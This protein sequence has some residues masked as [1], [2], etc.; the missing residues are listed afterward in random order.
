MIIDLR[1]WQAESWPAAPA[2]FLLPCCG[3]AARLDQPVNA[4][5]RPPEFAA[6]WAGRAS[7][8]AICEIR[9][10][11]WS[12]SAEEVKLVGDI[13]QLAGVDLRV[14]L[15]DPGVEAGL[16]EVRVGGQRAM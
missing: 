1:A 15:R 3:S 9:G 10:G 2:G 11:S 12:Y 8:R 16:V 4:L 7:L 5:L 14:A 6:D 13:D